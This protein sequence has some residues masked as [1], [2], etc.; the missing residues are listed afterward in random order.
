MKQKV[1][2]APQIT[3]D[4]IRGVIKE[5][6]NYTAHDIRTS[7]KKEIGQ[8]IREEITASEVRMDIKLEKLKFEIKDN[9]K[10]FRNDIFTK[11][12]SVMSELEKMREDQ[13][14]KVHNDVQ[15]KKR[16]DDHEKRIKKLETN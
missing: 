16:V 14:V 15:L 8:V 13:T 2:L 4:D 6:V 9:V 11:M 1:G 3:L 5:E 12:D 7:L 10:S